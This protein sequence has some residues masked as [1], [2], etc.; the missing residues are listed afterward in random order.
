MA[1]QSRL[2]QPKTL[3]STPAKASEGKAG[4]RSS[5]QNFA[6]LSG[7]W[8]LYEAVTMMAAPCLGSASACSS[9]A[10]TVAAKP[11]LR[12][13]SAMRCAMPSAVPRLEPN[14]TSS[15]VACA[16]AAAAGFATAAE[17][18]E[19]ALAAGS[20]VGAAACWGAPKNPIVARP[21][22]GFTRMMKFA[23]LIVNVCLV[24]S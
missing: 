3:Y 4:S 14:N 12:A 2:P 21:A 1:D 6:A 10:P 23:G 7:G 18:G 17:A 13:S 11:R 22:R 19:G 15:G 5:W 8:P 16:S 9:S 24:S 20:A